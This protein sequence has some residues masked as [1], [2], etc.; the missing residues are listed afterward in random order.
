MALN[1]LSGTRKSSLALKITPPP[2]LRMYS[3]RK[4]HTDFGVVSRVGA[5]R[6]SI[7]LLQLYTQEETLK[8]VCK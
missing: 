5:E 7:E 6:S 1:E 3:V 2:H 8:A 4:I